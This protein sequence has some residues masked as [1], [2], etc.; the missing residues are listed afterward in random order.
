MLQEN[1][2]ATHVYFPIIYMVQSQEGNNNSEKLQNYN[3]YDRKTSA[4]LSY[5]P[6]M[7]TSQ[8]SRETI[9]FTSSFANHLADTFSASIVKA[10]ETSICATIVTN[11]ESLIDLEPKRSHGHGFSNRR[12][13][14]FAHRFIRFYTSKASPAAT[15]RAFV[16]L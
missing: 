13:T 12:G 16:Y 14:I 2:R 11:I 1:A 9:N 8:K 6:Y 10:A 7:V 3:L 4:V 15:V 5:V